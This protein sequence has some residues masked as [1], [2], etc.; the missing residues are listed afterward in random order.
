MGQRGIM[1]S[2]ML[3]LNMLG[4]KRNAAVIVC[5]PPL[6]GLKLRQAYLEPLVPSRASVLGEVWLIRGIRALCPMSHQAGRGIVGSALLRVSA[7]GGAARA[8]GTRWYMYLVLYRSYVRTHGVS[9]MS[10][11]KTIWILD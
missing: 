9:G 11:G 4:R 1:C 5:G 2:R 3:W 10:S 8:S 6:V 7:N